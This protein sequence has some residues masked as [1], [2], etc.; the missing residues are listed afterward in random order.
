M[1]AQFVNGSNKRGFMTLSE[2]LARVLAAERSGQI[3][4]K[5][6]D[7]LAIRKWLTLA[8]GKVFGGGEPLGERQRQAA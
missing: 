5:E 3:F 2:R 8:E 7:R 1:D 4:L 6:R